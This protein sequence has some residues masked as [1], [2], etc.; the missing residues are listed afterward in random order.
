MKSPILLIEF[1]E[2]PGVV[3]FVRRASLNDR[4][5]RLEAPGTAP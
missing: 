2:A 3:H 4:P 5:Q 1:V